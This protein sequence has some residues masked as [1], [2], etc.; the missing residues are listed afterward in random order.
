[1]ALA[2]ALAVQRRVL[3]FDDMHITIIFVTHDQ[4]EAMELA[5]DVIVINQGRVEQ[6]VRPANSTATPPVRSS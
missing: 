2:R 1:M 6:S 5:D 4:E 3:L